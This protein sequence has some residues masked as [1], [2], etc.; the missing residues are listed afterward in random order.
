MLVMVLL[1]LTVVASAAW[2]QASIAGVVR[3]TSGAVLPGVTVEAASPVLIEKAR[4]AVTD[5]SGQYRVVDLRPGTYIVTFSLT[6]FATV[7]REG[8]ELTGSFTATVNADLRLGSL[9][10]TITVTG[11]SPIVDTQTVTQQR[12]LDKDLLDAIPT[13]R[14]HINV[15]IVIPGLNSSRV[16]VG[17]TNNLQLTQFQIHGGRQGDT[18]V[19]VNGAQT[20]NLFQN[21]STSNFLPDMGST[22]EIAIDYAAGSA[23]LATGGLRIDMIPKEGGN[24]FSGTVFATGVNSGFQGDNYSE[25]LA[26]QGLLAPNSLK[27]AYDINPS[28]GGPIRRDSLWFYTSSRWQAN[29]LYVAGLFE[30]KNAGDLTKWLYEADP[31]KQGVFDIKQRNNNLRLTWQASQRNKFQFFFEDQG[32]PWDDV[33]AGVSPEAATRYRFKK[34]W[35]GNVSW[36]LPLTSRLLIDARYSDH[37]EVFDHILPP[38]GSVERQLI[39]VRE[40]SNALLYRGRGLGSRTPFGRREAPNINEIM[41]SVSYVTG[42]HALKFGMTNLWGAESNVARNNDYHLEFRFNNGIPNQLSQ[43]ATPYSEDYWLNDVGIYAQDKWTLRR[44]TINAGLRF[45]YQYAYFPEVHLGPTTWIPNRNVTFAKSDS[46]NYKDLTPRFG[47]AYN[48]FGDG[49]TAIKVNASKFVLG[50]NAQDNNPVT[51]MANVVPRSWNDVDRDYVPDCDLLN[52]LANGECGQL[53]DL[54]FG[55]SR[56][57]TVFDPDTKFGWRKREYNWEFSTSVQHQLIPRVGLDVG[58]FRRIFGNFTVVDNRAV[59]PAD[60]GR[61]SIPAPFDPRLPDGGGYIVDG[62]YNLNPDKVGQVDNYLTYSSHYGEQ[63]EHWH[64]IDLTVN[65]RPRNGVL[66]Q[67]GLSTGKTTMDNCEVVDDLPEALFGASALGVANTN[68]WQ[69]QDQCHQESPFLTQIKLLGTYT[70]PK[71]DIAIAGMFQSLP[72]TRVLANFVAPNSLVQPSLGRPLSGGAANVTVNI[73][74]PGAEY[75][76]QANQF[77][78]R[79]SKIFRFG[80]TRAQV[81]FD[82]YNI[83]N[84]NP[85]L[86]VNNAYA[87]WLT[88]QS[89]MDARLFR[90]SGQFDF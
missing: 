26:A 32:R 5:G 90:I 49:N 12:V 24:R 27:L 67:G 85:V 18:R 1:L 33:R 80:G 31:T 71:I 65:A 3:D 20:R 21:G 79:F 76:E 10:E 81:N 45:D 57:S 50:T 44:L 83:F 25:E 15:A 53:T 82:L 22:Q 64:G 28:F 42:S 48:L 75:T 30:N 16:D 40:Q 55:G 2:A 14:S 29:Q 56:P 35:M 51:N 54:N 11:E 63:L 60:F 84:A 13:G 74:E 19:L 73:V 47:L 4:S 43:H 61:F 58:Y 87:S 88:P 36:T 86:T 9:E 6:G 39:P 59:T 17:G 78:V 68:V 69:P 70:I 62:L 52:S 7:K 34:N 41:G 72:G 37:A 89:I 23:E 46:V 77:D 8:I 66:L 38:E